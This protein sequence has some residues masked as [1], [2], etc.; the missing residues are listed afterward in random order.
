MKTARQVGFLTEFKSNEVF[1]YYLNVSATIQEIVT[2][3]L[4]KVICLEC[5]SI[6]PP[7]LQVVQKL[8]YIVVAARRSCRVLG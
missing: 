1:Q 7:H 6:A 5:E 2:V 4:C 8:L 3:S